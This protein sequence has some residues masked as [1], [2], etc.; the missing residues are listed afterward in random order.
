[1]TTEE[2]L[3][4]L[5]IELPAAPAPA[6]N[7]VPAY[8]TGN[9]L[10]LSGAICL[11]NGE[12]THTGKVGAER[13]LAYGQAAARV[14]ALNLLAVAKAYLGDLDKIKQ[15]V[16]LGGFVNGAPS[17]SDSPAVINGASDTMVEILGDRG[18][19]TRAAV[20]VTGLPKDTTVEITA[21]IEVN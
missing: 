10:Y 6:G 3:N 18:R 21:V 13:D 11:V 8:Q 15:V 2:R 14:C 5:G 17:F 16:H 7:Y 20:A 12:M 19:H 4:E 1:M 9:L